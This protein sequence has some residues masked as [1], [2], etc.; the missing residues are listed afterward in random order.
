M[1]FS[2]PY[3]PFEARPSFPVCFPSVFARV[4]NRIR[5]P[6]SLPRLPMR[7]F[8]VFAYTDAEPFANM[9]RFLEVRALLALDSPL[10]S[11]LLPLGAASWPS[12]CCVLAFCPLCLHLLTDIHSTSVR[13]Q[14]PTQLVP[15]ALRWELKVCRGFEHAGAFNMRGLKACDVPLRVLVPPFGHGKPHP[16]VAAAPAEPPLSSLNACSRDAECQVSTAITDLDLLRMSVRIKSG[17]RCISH[18]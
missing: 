15:H 3:L 13:S 5:P 8:S 17:Q 1:P 16:S 12:D 14:D 7:V 9:T 11:P 10:S 2:P 4:P 18:R 6:V